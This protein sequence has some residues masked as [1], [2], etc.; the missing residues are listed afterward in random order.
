MVFYDCVCFVWL[1]VCVDKWLCVCRLVVVRD[2]CFVLISMC[3]DMI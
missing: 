1:C 2:V 3:Y